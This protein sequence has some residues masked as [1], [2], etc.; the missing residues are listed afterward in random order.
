MREGAVLE[1]K[2][3]G[4]LVDTVEDHLVEEYSFVWNQEGAS[5][6]E[7]ARRGEIV[8]EEN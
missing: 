5:D 4:L 6:G 3:V 2:F 8:V 1:E 7:R